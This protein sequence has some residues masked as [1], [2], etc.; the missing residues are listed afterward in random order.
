MNAGT[1]CNFYVQRPSPPGP[2]S[3]LFSFLAAFDRTWQRDALAMCCPCPCIQ[4]MRTISSQVIT[5]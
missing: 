3:H 5:N 4:P 1:P 2:F